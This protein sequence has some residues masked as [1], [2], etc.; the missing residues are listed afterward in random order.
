MSTPPCSAATAIAASQVAGSS[1]LPTT[2]TTPIAA[3]DCSARPGSNSTPTTVA[4]SATN[5]SAAAHPIPDPTPEMIAVL[6]SSRPMGRDRTSRQEA[7]GPIGQ[8]GRQ[9]SNLGGATDTGPLS[10]TV[11]VQVTSA[12]PAAS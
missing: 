9:I 2:G 4:P 6:P 7:G 5:R 8:A 11:V 12:S 1:T 3:A 10:S